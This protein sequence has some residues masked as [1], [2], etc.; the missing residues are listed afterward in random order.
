[1]G[2]VI[3]ANRYRLVDN[4]AFELPLPLSFEIW[5]EQ[6]PV[7]EYKIEQDESVSCRILTKYKETMLTPLFRPLNINDIYYLMSC[8]V[9]QD[10]TPYTAY[11]LERLG[12]EKYSVYEILRKT[13]GVTPYDRYWLRF[14]GESCTYESVFESFC[15]VMEPP[16]TE[17][18]EVP[19]YYVQSQVI[20]E[21]K[22][23]QRAADSFVRQIAE[24]SSEA[25][26]APAEQSG[27]VMSQEESEKLTAS[28]IA[29]D[30]EP[31]SE[32]EPLSGAKMT[33]DEIEALLSSV[34]LGINAPEPE[35][36][37]AEPSDGK[38]SQDAIEA[39]FAAQAAQPEPTPA[40]SSDGKM[41]QDAIEALFAA[42]AAQP[43]PSPAPA[44]PSDGKMSQDAI[45]ALFAAQAAQP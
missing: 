26:S 10:R 20:S 1:M 16:P 42:Q 5:K 18:P 45:E 19:P 25:A 37:P 7:A 24:Q 32:P 38:M 40:E 35:A 34:G 23:P 30:P 13:H 9:F 15:K 31:V 36:A 6:Y 21:Y 11:Q 29:P 8:R 22:T 17:L 44:E 39:L 12:L 3:K 27:G 4:H 2:S 33:Q 14:D 41:S 28:M 43:E